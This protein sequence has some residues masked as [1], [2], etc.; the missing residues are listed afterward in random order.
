MADLAEFVLTAQRKRTPEEKEFIW[1]KIIDGRL[2]LYRR[3]Y[4]TVKYNKN[5]FQKFTVLEF[6]GGE[7]FIC[8]RYWKIQEFDNHYLAGK[9]YIPDCNCFIKCPSCES[10]LYDLQYV[11]NQKLN[12]CDNCGW[13]LLDPDGPIWKKR[14]GA[15]FEIFYQDLP[16]KTKARMRAER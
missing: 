14:Y 6:E 3:W 5:V 12:H 2:A 4:R 10:N 7:C 11:Y 16:E 9:Y 1:S 13:L 8:H 15:E